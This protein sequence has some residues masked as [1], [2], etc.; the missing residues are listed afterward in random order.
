FVVSVLE[1]L[2]PPQPGERAEWLLLTAKLRWQ[3]QLQPFGERGYN[4]RVQFER[5]RARTI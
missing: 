2:P 1:E 3:E 5:E 4:S